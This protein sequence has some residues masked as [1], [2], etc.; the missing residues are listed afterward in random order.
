AGALGYNAAGARPAGRSAGRKVRRQMEIRV[1][2]G[3]L[4]DVAT[5]L[6][7]V[8]LFEDVEALGGAT[9]AVDEA[10]GGLLSRLRSAAELRG[11]ACDVVVVHNPGNWPL[12]AERVAVVGLGR[13]ADFTAE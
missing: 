4:N 9:A 7:V 10:T 1:E 6:L 11:R 3:S 13:R 2:Q 8:N 12:Q 5:P